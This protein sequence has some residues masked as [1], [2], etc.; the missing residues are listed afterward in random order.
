M[1][2]LRLLLL[3]LTLLLAA[4]AQAADPLP[5]WADRPVKHAILDWLVA[6]T[7]TAGADFIP[8]PERI[9]VLDN[10]GT[11][12]CERP[13]YSPTQFQVDL[14]RSLAA[15]GA[16]D[17]EAM[18][19]RAWFADDRKDLRSYG[20][21]KAYE[22]MNEAFAGMPVSDFRDSVRAWIARTPHERYGVP[23]TDLYYPAML[24]LMRL[25]EAHDFQVWIVTGGIQEFLRSYSEELLGI[26]PE[27]VI[28][29][30]DQPKYTVTADGTVVIVRGRDVITNGG[31]SK[32]A[33]IEMRIGRRPVFAA[34]NSDNDEPMCRYAVTGK[35]RALALWI[36]H[37][38]GRREYDYGKPGDLG[39]LCRDNDRAHEVSM[40]H[41]W[42]RIFAEGIGE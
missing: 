40:K 14:C 20:Y 6:V 41:D 7:D 3:L 2:T 25:L 30:T 17:G 39:D 22:A 38:D 5:S 4:A 23:H 42:N 15:R 12:W 21:D 1:R 31:P 27:R 19:F 33:N 36:H 13:E 28:G 11:L 10:D 24:E 18:P 35:R 34:G 37:D 9:A 32:P 8:V 16:I 29:T 26:P